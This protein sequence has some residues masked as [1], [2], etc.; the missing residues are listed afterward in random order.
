MSTTSAACNCFDVTRANVA[1]PSPAWL[2]ARRT[3]PLQASDVPATSSREPS[4]LPLDARS[5]DPLQQK[6][7]YAHHLVL[8]PDFSSYRF[9]PTPASSR[10]SS[11]MS[12]SALDRP[13]PSRLDKAVRPD[14]AEADE[15]D[16]DD[17]EEEQ[18]F[19]RK[20]MLERREFD[21]DM[22]DWNVDDDDRDDVLERHD[23]TE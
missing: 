22:E 12:S 23:R 2:D 14:R 10:P 19:M 21:G 11:P 16:S 4:Y 8:R 5:S 13:G 7:S 18:R 15:N 1:P 17:D 3:P 6:L 9:P 20:V